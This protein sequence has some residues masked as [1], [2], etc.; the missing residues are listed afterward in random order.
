VENSRAALL[1]LEN[2]VGIGHVGMTAETAAGLRAA[3]AK[4][5]DA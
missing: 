1:V 2:L 3:L 5:G 4:F